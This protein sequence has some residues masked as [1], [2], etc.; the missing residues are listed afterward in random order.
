MH[1]IYIV[2]VANNH[3]IVKTFLSEEKATSYVKWY[4]KLGSPM[5]YD[6]DSDGNPL[7]RKENLIVCHYNIDTEV[8]VY[9]ESDTY[10]SFMEECSRYGYKV[11]HSSG[12]NARPSVFIS[13]L[14]NELQKVIRCTTMLLEYGRVKSNGSFEVWPAA[15][16]KVD[17]REEYFDYKDSFRKDRFYTDY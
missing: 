5:H 17:Y 9:Y 1:K 6:T 13:N 8:P 16:R 11:Q 14:D 12:E 4:D 7:Y 15:P 2:C 3:K 10:N